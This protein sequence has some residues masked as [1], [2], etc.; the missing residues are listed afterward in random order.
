LQ[1]F[2]SFFVFYLWL[3]KTVLYLHSQLSTNRAISSAGSE[4]P[5]E[6]GRVRKEKI[7]KYLGR[8]AQL[9]QSIP[10]K[11]GGSEKKRLRNI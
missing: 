2:Y 10:M 7:K 11:S 6:I 3:P 8:L 9:V 5:D 1:K 4:H